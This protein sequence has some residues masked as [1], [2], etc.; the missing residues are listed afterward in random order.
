MKKYNLKNRYN[1][2]NKIHNLI[3][4][5]PL[6]NKKKTLK[7]DKEINYY[8]LIYIFCIFVIY[9]SFDSNIWNNFYF[10][11]LNHISILI[12]SKKYKKHSK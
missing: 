7:N 3:Y 4:L 1:M 12:L 10:I 5:Q 9:L 8:V 2:K 6:M 11:D